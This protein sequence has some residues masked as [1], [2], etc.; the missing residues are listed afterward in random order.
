MTLFR[1][2]DNGINESP[3]IDRYWGKHGSGTL[4]R[5]EIRI[6]NERSSGFDR[7]EL[8]IKTSQ[9]TEPVTEITLKGPQS[10]QSEVF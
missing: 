1:G 5:N 7:S 10:D 4:G 2:E 9:K 6:N 3:I 8:S